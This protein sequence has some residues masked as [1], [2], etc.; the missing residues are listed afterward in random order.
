MKFSKPAISLI[1]VFLF[2]ALG[3]LSAG[4][5]GGTPAPTPTQAPTATPTPQE[6]YVNLIGE[7]ATLDPSR[8]SW[9]SEI[10]VIRQVFQGLLGYNQDLTLKALVAKEIPSVE[11]GGVSGDGLVITFKLREAVKWSDGKPVTAADF[12]YS[13]KRLLDP[14]VAAPYAHFY[15]GI[16][17]ACEYNT[18]AGEDLTELAGL[19]NAVGVKALDD[20]TLEFTLRA[21][22]FTFLQLMALPPASP[23]REDIISENGSDWT[24]PETYIGN[25]PFNVVE[26]VHQSH[27]ILEAN[28]N[29]W[30]PKAE[31]ERI[32][33]VMITDATAAYAAYLNDELD[34]VAVPIGMEAELMTDPELS[35]QIL[36][37]PQLSTFGFLFNIT[38]PP[39]DNLTVRQAFSMAIDREAFINNVRQGIGKVAYS[40]I[41]PGMPGHQPELGKQYEFNATAARELLAGVGYPDGNGL[42]AISFEYVDTPANRLIAQFFQGQIKENLGVDIILEPMEPKSFSQLIG[43]MMFTWAFFGWTADY[44]DP[45]NWLPGV[46]MTGAG[47]NFMGYSN[48]QFD[49]LAQQAMSEPDPEK[50]LQIWSE[51]QT[52]VVQDAPLI[53][54]LYGERF[55]LVKPYIQ[56]L[57]STA[58]D[59]GIPGDMFLYEVS[60]APR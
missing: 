10:T 13:M 30:G 20:E 35:K 33:L 1:S 25:G 55:V 43:Q 53:S 23:L 15:Y 3:V 39:F 40:W 27:I 21:P 22:G 18:Y 52:I 60:I 46:F 26:W 2:L 38:K 56:G 5:G 41:P 37:Q 28:P 48:P 6:L 7:P 12:E 36:R 58:M 57:K 16:E 42:P 11:N 59:A 29:Y 34:I 24:N 54:M 45:D 9:G 32:K 19:R 14:E 17:G 51:A 4:G 31:L 44:P 50:R 8:T 47:V 49:E